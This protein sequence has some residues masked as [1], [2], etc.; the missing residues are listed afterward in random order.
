M[1][2][3]AAKGTIQLYPQVQQPLGPRNFI[4]EAHS[5]VGENIIVIE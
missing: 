5:R 3:N 1:V 2:N 4:R